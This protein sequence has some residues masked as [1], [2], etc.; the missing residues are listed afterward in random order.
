MRTE[1]SNLLACLDY[2]AGGNRQARVVA[3]TAA[4]ATLLR[5]DG[6]WVDAQ[7]RHAAAAEAARQLGDRPGQANALLEL[8]TVRWLTG[9]YPGAT[10]AEQE[11]LGISRDLGD[12]LGQANALTDLA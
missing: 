1:R 8:G 5:Q 3:L 7:T 12:R 6:P 11:A 2:A 9:D 10:V 4:L